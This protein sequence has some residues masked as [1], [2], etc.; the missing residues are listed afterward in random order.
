MS[1]IGQLKN[2][3]RK[4]FTIIEVSLF[5][6]ITGFIF[7]GMI[8][9]V[10]SSLRQNHYDDDVSSLVDF[11]Q[12]AYSKVI[13]VE[14]DKNGQS[15]KAIYGK[16]ITFGETKNLAKESNEEDKDVFIYD[17]IGDVKANYNGS[18]LQ[19]IASYNSNVT[20]KEIVNGTPQIV[21]TGIADSY[22]TR[23]GSTIESVYAN[24]L[25]LTAAILILRSPTTG[26]VFTYVNK[27]TTLDV[28]AD[29]AAGRENTLLNALKSGFFS[30]AGAELDI[31]VNMDGNVYGGRR[32]NIRIDKLARS[33]SG[34]RLMHL[35]D[36]QNHC[37]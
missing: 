30:S 22:R 5:L 13:S 21:F 7:I 17:V 23:W 19:A 4:G 11:L 24:H 9:G 27:T 26:N 6:A 2:T 29:R 33:S 10:Q 18:T 28:N 16:L 8:V 32:K 37:L 12:N 20:Q 35:D 31:C 1:I 36:S 15:D 14:N 3:H 34:V 25:P